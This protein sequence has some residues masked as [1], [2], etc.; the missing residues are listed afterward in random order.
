MPPHPRR[1]LLG[2]ISAGAR[3]LIEDDLLRTH[4]ESNRADVKFIS[5][6]LTW[7]DNFVFLCWACEIF[8]SMSASEKWR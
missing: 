6:C 3:E 7:I 1:I 8:H 4:G 5:Q 2:L